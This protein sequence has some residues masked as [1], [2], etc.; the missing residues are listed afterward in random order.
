MNL[1]FSP[2]FLFLVQTIV[3]MIA[4]MVVLYAAL[5]IGASLHPAAAEMFEELD[6]YLRRTLA[7]FMLPLY[8]G[9]MD[10]MRLQRGGISVPTAIGDHIRVIAGIAPVSS[11]G[12]T[13]VGANATTGFDRTGFNS[14]V[15]VAQTGLSGAIT[16]VDAKIRHCDTIGGTYT[17][18]QPDGTAASGAITQITANSTLQSKNINLLG[19]KQ[20]V[21]VSLTIVGTSVLVE[22]HLIFGGAVTEPA[23]AAQ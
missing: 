16:S 22:S 11:S 4:S 9:F 2:P 23:S 14:C 8:L 5:A 19:A 13:L 10:T 7:A 1:S 17:D 3:L 12:A 21:Q 20:F 18:F 6:R 15:L